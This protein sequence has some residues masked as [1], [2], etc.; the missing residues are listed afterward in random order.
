MDECE[1]PF[2]EKKD[3]CFSADLFNVKD[4]YK[5]CVKVF[6][7]KVLH[8]RSDT[9]WHNVIGLSKD[10]RPQW[11]ALYNPP[12]PKR[13]GDMHWRIL[14]GVIAVNAFISV[15]NQRLA[16]IVLFALREKPFFMLLCIAID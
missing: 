14:H 2:L 10:F 9:P 16:V 8:N 5:N 13:A 7:R 11:R 12:L 3:V 4:V 15:I 1:G 6:N